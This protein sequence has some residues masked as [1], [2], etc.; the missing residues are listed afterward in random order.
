MQRQKRDY[1]KKND[2]W[3]EKNIFVNRE[4]K[5]SSI[6]KEMQNAELKYKP[7]ESKNVDASPI[8]YTDKDGLKEMTVDELKA[9]LVAAG[10]KTRLRKKE[11][12]IELL[13]EK[14]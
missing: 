5:R 3:W 9:K 6:L 14:I 11:K 4:Q 1:T 13:I 7:I 12:L 10:V 8:P 2:E